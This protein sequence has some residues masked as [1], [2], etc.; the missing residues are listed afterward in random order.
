MS[1]TLPT[2]AQALLSRPPMRAVFRLG[3]PLALASFFQAGFN[4]TEVWVFGQVGDGGASRSG[5]A[6]SDMLTAIFALLASGLGNAAVAQISTAT[7]A[8]DEDTA[9]AAARAAI[10]VGIVLSVLSAVVGVL[11]T[12]IGDAFMQTASRPPGIAFLRIMALGGFGTVFMV[13]S[14][15]ILRARGDSVRPLVLI[16][17]VSIATLVLESVF[18]LGLFGVE[19]SGIVPA[20]WITVILRG[21]T[22]AWGVWMVS[23]KLSL[24]AP[25]G[26]RF[27]DKAILRE[28]IRLG[29]LSAVQQSVRVLGMLA[30]VALATLR[31]GEDASKDVFAAMAM[32]SKV[33]IPMIMLAFAWGG[34]TSPIVGMALGA[35]RPDHAR[36]AAW[37]GARIAGMAALVNTA[38]V[39]LLAPMLIQAFAPGETGVISTTTALLDHVAPFYPAMAI[40]IAVAFAFNGAGDMVR[41][42]LADTIVLVIIQS[43]LAYI[44]GSPDVMGV[45]GF[46]VALSIS[47]V[48]QGIVPSFLLW[49]ARFFA[50]THAHPSHDAGT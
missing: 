39:L 40:G 34:G 2:E 20:A 25:K 22:G 16:A 50:H 23:R 41:P 12:P 36:R 35:G 31:L 9:S 13:V 37:A 3:L 10:F 26:E 11:A 4:L 5:A 6:V 24:R 19:P 46:F 28:Q 27:V 15:G 17:C 49:R 14:V 45:T 30:M 32:W 48:L 1:S 47:G 21:L 44:L 33:D 42:L 18:V 43:T 29:L 8:R 7:G 38:L